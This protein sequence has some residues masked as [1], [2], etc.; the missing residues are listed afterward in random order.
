M[1]IIPQPAQGANR[2]GRGKLHEAPARRRTIMM[3]RHQC[4]TPL[5]VGSSASTARPRLGGFPRLTDRSCCAGAS[6]VPMDDQPVTT[7]AAAAVAA[8]SQQADWTGTCLS[9]RRCHHACCRRRECSL[10]ANSQH[11]TGACLSRCI[12]VGHRP[13]ACS[14]ACRS[15]CASR[16]HRNHHRRRA[17][18]VRPPAIPTSR[19]PPWP[20]PLQPAEY[21]HRPALV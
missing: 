16:F 18:T 14:G 20:S 13:A 17:S 10:P 2:R 4:Q 7:V 21:F 5:P 1:A 6:A 19:R 9:N 3:S 8:R 12:N 11:S 15:S